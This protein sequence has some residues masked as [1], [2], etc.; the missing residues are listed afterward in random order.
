[1]SSSLTAGSS[2]PGFTTAAPSSTGLSLDA[3]DI[4]VVVIYFV[5]VMVVGIWSSVRANRST[6]GGYFL[7]GRSM[8]WWPVSTY[9]LTD[10][11]DVLFSISC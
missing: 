4:A 6:V 3:A 5:F 7:A 2:S 9:P 8:T 11:H 10:V 1:M